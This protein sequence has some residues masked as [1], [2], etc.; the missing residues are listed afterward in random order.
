MITTNPLSQVSFLVT[1]LDSAV[2]TPNPITNGSGSIT[3]T[4]LNSGATVLAPTPL[5]QIGVTNQ[6]YYIVSAADFAI[7][8]TLLFTVTAKDSGG[9]TL[10]TLYQTIKTA[11]VPPP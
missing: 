7:G 9:N 1:M 10:K 11:A 4:D 8:A 5:V 2:P 3:A 6:Y